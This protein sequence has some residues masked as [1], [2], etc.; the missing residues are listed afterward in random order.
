MKRELKDKDILQA[1]LDG[2]DV[3]LKYDGTEWRDWV[4]NEIP[5]V[6][7]EYLEWR[8][9]PTEKWVNLYKDS[10][11]SYFIG[12]G[13]YPSHDAAVKV[14]FAPGGIYLKSILV[15]TE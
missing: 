2:K 1:W 6:A 11:G 4:G 8:I 14:T 9:K 3:Q 15:E 13:V 12:D 10:S 5:N 7:I